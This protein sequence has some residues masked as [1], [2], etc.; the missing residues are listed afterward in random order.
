MVIPFWWSPSTP[1]P[2][3]GCTK[4]AF[5]WSCSKSEERWYA[6]MAQECEEEDTA[7]EMGLDF[8]ERLAGDCERCQEP[9]PDLLTVVGGEAICD[10]CVS[11][12]VEAC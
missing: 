1:M 9:Q 3:G 8:G 6:A 12:E 11:A 5:G 7:R 4:N 2:P 10:D